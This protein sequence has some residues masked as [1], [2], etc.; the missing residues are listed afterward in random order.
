[1]DTNEKA[2]L[3]TVARVLRARVKEEIFDPAGQNKD[4]YRM[5]D[6]ALKP[7]DPSPIPGGNFANG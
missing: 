1:M 5:L 6:D 3:L 2:L 7:F 4:D